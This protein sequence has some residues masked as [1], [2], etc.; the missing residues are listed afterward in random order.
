MD[1][2][3][4][5]VVGLKNIAKLKGLKRY[6][7][8]RKADLIEIIKSKAPELPTKTLYESELDACAWK[9]ST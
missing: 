1:I 9:K 6:S 2:N 7:R 5:G 8:L 4:R 3:G